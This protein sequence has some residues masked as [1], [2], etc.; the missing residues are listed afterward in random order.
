MNSSVHASICVRRYKSDTWW[1]TILRHV[2]L[3]DNLPCSCPWKRKMKQC[4]IL[5]WVS[6]YIYIYVLEH[7]P[8]YFIMTNIF[9]ELLCGRPA[10]N[11]NCQVFYIVWYARII[12]L[13]VPSQKRIKSTI[14]FV[15]KSGMR[16]ISNLGN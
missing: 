16:S 6:S 13:P 15:L 11:H 2:I 10:N 4:Q 8:S 9:N 5:D 3:L 14:L 12:D 7:I 1:L